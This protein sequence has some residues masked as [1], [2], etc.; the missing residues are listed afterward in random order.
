[1]WKDCTL[2]I[3]TKIKLLKTLA[4]PVALYGSKS[5][6]FKENDIDMLKAFE[7]TCYGCTLRISWR[8]H[9]TNESVLNEIGT[10][11]RTGRHCKETEIAALWAH[12]Q[13]IEPQL[14]LC[15]RILEGR[16]DGAR[17]RGRPTRR[18]GDDIKDWTGKTLADCATTARDRKSWRELVR[19]SAVSNLQQ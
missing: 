19:R 4:W 1:M 9:R 17:G 14:Y 7:M 12:D 8:D 2:V 18:W 15:I 3:Q 6:T 13:S 5:W 16:L 11:T 10:E